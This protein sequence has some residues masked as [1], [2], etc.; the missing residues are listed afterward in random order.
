ME[1]LCQKVDLK[2]NMKNLEITTI[3]IQIPQNQVSLKI[4][5]NKPAQLLNKF[6]DL[7]KQLF[8][9]KIIDKITEDFDDVLKS[10]LEPKKIFDKYVKKAQNGIFSTKSQE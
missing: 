6:M 8:I 1:I 4:D 10:K 9:S 7:A 5:G 2:I 3:N